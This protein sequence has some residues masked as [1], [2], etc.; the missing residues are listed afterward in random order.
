LQT[1]SFA[2][3]FRNPSCLLQEK[4]L[5]QEKTPVYIEEN[6]PTREYCSLSSLCKKNGE[7]FHRSIQC[8]DSLK[9]YTYKKLETPNILFNLLNKR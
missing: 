4:I 2:M 8:F 1:P 7:T 5:L 3:K 9:K 6:S